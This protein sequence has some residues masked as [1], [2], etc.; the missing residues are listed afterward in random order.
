MFHQDVEEGMKLTELDK[1]LSGAD[2]FLTESDQ[3]GK[4][5]EYSYKGVSK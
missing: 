2:K 3:K 1:S 5:L 4:T